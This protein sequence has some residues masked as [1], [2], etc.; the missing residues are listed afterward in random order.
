MRSSAQSHYE[1]HHSRPFI[2]MLRG[3]GSVNAFGQ[4]VEWSLLDEES[5]III[6]ARSCGAPRGER[7][8]GGTT[9]VA[10]IFVEVRIR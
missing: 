4:Y 2:S 10:P 5:I 3:R 6:S 1:C 7:K 8:N 9:G